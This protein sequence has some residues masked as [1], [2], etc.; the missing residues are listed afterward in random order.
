MTE[1]KSWH[2]EGLD[3]GPRP[4]VGTDGYQHCEV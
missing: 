4:I 2:R 1:L 3:D